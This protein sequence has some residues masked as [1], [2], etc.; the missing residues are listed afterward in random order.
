[1][2]PG[3]IHAK[4][5]VIDDEFALTGSANL[6]ERSFFLNYE[7][8]IAFYAPSEI[9]QFSRWIEANRKLAIPYAAQPPN[10]S[11]EFVEGLVRWIAFQL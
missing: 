5:I 7:L 4:A 2:L 1:M 10:V 11:R 6:D 3:M 8:M 9:E